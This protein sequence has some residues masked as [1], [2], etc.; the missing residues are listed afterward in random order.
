VPGTS[1]RGCWISLGPLPEVREIADLRALCDEVVERL[2]DALPDGTGTIVVEGAGRVAGVPTKLRQV[3]ANLIRNAVEAAGPR[4]VVKIRVHQQ[5]QEARVEIE[6]TGP[7]IDGGAAGRLFEPFFT[8]K[9]KG[10]G[11]GLAVS[12]AI[13]RAHGGDVDGE[14]IPIG[15]ARFTLR[16]PRATT[17]ATP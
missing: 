6:D 4:G 5:A 8:T 12:R 14:S 11:L 3:L 15:G 9:D 1:W 2:R 7:G 17:E 13:A 10:T 16:L